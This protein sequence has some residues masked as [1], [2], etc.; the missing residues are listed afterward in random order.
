MVVKDRRFPHWRK[1]KMNKNSRRNVTIITVLIIS[2]LLISVLFKFG[3]RIPVVS[4]YFLE[5]QQDQQ[6][7][8]TKESDVEYWTCAMHPSVKMKDPG[9]CPICGM[10]L[11]PA[12]RKSPSGSMKIDENAMDSGQSGSMDQM[13]DHSMHGMSPGTSGKNNGSS[14]FTVDTRR[15]Q[16]I[17]VKTEPVQTR[18]MIKTIRTVGTVELDETKIEH[19]HTKFSGWIEEV[20]VDYQWQHVKKG[21]PLFTIYSPELVSTQEEYLLALRSKRILGD[22]KFEDISEGTESLVKASRNRLKLWDVSES[23]IREIEKTGKVKKSITIYSPITGHVSYKNAFENQYVEPQSLIYT[24]ADHTT[25]WV[26]AEIYEDEIPLVGL[27][28]KATLT[29]ESYPDEEFHGEI[30]FKWPHLMPKTRTTRVRFEFPNP[31]LKLLPEMYADVNLEIPLGE[32]LSIPES[33]VLRTGKQNIVFVDKGNGYM[34]IRK[35]ELGRKAGNYYEVNKGLNE[36]EMVVARANFLIDAESKLQAA[37]A[38]WGDGD[39]GESGDDESKKQDE[40]NKQ[41]MDNQHVH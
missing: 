32:R 40:R 6:A 5:K 39:T 4:E 24:I 2:L 34:D 25:A 31:D 27:G 12:G 35:V 33:A 16:L 9:T 22:S 7:S 3:D 11:V 36:G 1:I 17:N 19:I 29:V 21:D 13:Q 18:E 15:Q 28:Q 14:E 20:F 30:T 41:P 26:N 10:D 23:Q 8:A 38:T 37:I